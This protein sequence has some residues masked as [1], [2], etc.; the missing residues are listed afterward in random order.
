MIDVQ[1]LTYTYPAFI[2]GGAR[3]IALH[4]VS[5]H[6]D[7]GQCL[8]V[9]GPNNCGK[10]TLCLAVA[11]L[12]PRLTQG[13]ITGQ[14]LIDERDV[15]AE[16]PG[17]LADRVGLLMQEPAGQMFNRSVEHEIAWGLENLGISPAEMEAR[18][19][20]ALAMVGLEHVPRDQ[21]PLSLSGGEQK[22]LA[23]ASA[24]A[25]EPEVLILDEPAG[26]LSPLGRREM[27]AILSQLRHETGLTILLAESDP[28]LIIGL[29]DE[30][31]VVVEGKIIQRGTP[32]EI[33]AELDPIAAA[34][35]VLP[36]SLIFA[37]A[38]DESQVVPTT[39]DEAAELASKYPKPTMSP[40]PFGSSKQPPRLSEDA[41]V[42]EDI[43]FAYE[44]KR[45]ILR[46]ITLH[47]GTGEF[48]VLS[49]DNG[50]GKTT[51]ARHLI[52]LLR[53]DRGQVFIQG[54][55]IAGMSIGQIAPMVGFAYQNPE[56]QIFNPTVQEEIAFGPHNLG[57]TEAEI[58]QTVE[59]ALTQFHLNHV[60]DSPPSVL[61][62]STRRMVA[63]AS[64]AAMRTPIL[65]LDEPT[66]GL[67]V[68]G[69]MRVMEWLTTAHDAGTTVLFITH[70]MELAARCAER[71]V[72]LDDGKITADGPPAEVFKRSDVLVQAGLEAPFAV[73]LGQR[74]GDESLA[75]ALTPESAARLLRDRV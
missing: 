8:A 29:A 24:L 15:Q 52:G 72:V 56:L 60:Q 28:D 9:T 26:G 55:N 43:A 64:I 58:E 37:Q 49:G 33:Y 23:L 25:L 53:P 47:I 57:M 75:S 42:L 5:F 4:R 7:K 63:L 46:D 61:S 44:P 16:K 3:I 12:A 59:D 32:R 20:Q 18:I 22:R 11:G 14:V 36:P 38:L 54:Q 65:V 45:P 34:G 17:M 41:I 51:L 66:V 35:V 39:I 73:R 68:A 31:L 21:P 27:A 50:A 40:E 62:F 19:E 71:I 70:D 10:T 30:M 6:V 13:K 69:Q 48:I 2:P 67:D 1:E 74:V